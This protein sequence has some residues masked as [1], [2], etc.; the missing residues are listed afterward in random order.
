MTKF[1]RMSSLRLHSYE[2][3]KSTLAE[4]KLLHVFLRKIL[5]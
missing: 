2:T 3:A 5:Q 4:K 1:S